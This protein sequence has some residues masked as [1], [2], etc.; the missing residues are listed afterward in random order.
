[1]SDTH[2]IPLKMPQE[3]FVDEPKEISDVN[4]HDLVIDIDG[5]TKDIN[6]FFACEA[7]AVLL[8]TLEDIMKLQSDPELFE[9]FRARSLQQSEV[10]LKL[11]NPSVDSLESD[12][13]VR[14]SPTPSPP[15][16]K[17]MKVDSSTN[18]HV[19]GDY[20]AVLKETTPDS[21]VDSTDNEDIEVIDLQHLID[22]TN[23]TLSNYVDFQDVKSEI[24]YYQDPM[25]KSQNKLVVKVFD[26][27]APPKLSI[28][29]FLQRIRTYSSAISVSCYI[30]AAFLVYKLAFLH[31]I[32]VLTPCNVYRLILA[33]IR[34]STKILED[35][36]Q[37]QKTFATVGG[38]SQKE[39]FKIEVG[40]LFLCNFRLV[41]NEDSLNHYLKSFSQLRTFVKENIDDKTS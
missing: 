39:L 34:C 9:Q 23:L 30:H 24:T 7:I 35:I 1:M 33:S 40:F 8:Y 17:I 19:G 37:K 4:I 2:E 32:I 26:L 18:N 3:T 16:S 38:V 28:E 6:K 27:V 12:I 11:L 29:Q 41:V 21:L 25:V 36:Y 22:T 20:D 15:P 14:T 13:K 5:N 10:D 31:K